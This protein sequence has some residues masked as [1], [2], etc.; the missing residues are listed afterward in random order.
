MLFFLC[1]IDMHRL[2]SFGPSGTGETDRESRV[3]SIRT[4]VKLLTQRDSSPV[5]LDGPLVTFAQRMRT[6]SRI[7]LSNFFIP[8]L[9]SIAQ[10]IVVYRDVNVLVVNEIVL[11]NTMLAVFGVVFATVWSGNIS[12]REAEINLREDASP[13]DDD[14]MANRHPRAFAIPGLE[15]WHVASSPPTLTFRSIGRTLPTDGT[16]LSVHGA[17]DSEKGN[18]QG[19][20]WLQ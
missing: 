4:E 13:I 11:V 15:T 14:A 10:L 20:S 12:R 6:L 19:T 18:G 17:F 2:H 5:E 1:R 7:A 16:G 3:T 9:F 8:S